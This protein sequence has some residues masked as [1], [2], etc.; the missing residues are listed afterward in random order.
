MLTKEELFSFFKI[1]SEKHED[2]KTKHRGNEVPEPVLEVEIRYKPFESNFSK[3]IFDLSLFFC[4]KLNLTF[5]Q[6]DDDVVIYSRQNLRKI[7]K[8]TPEG[9]IAQ[10]LVQ[11]KDCLYHVK[12]TFVGQHNL[13]CECKFT[14]SSEK[15]LSVG[16]S[17]L[18]CPISEQR[19]R[20]RRTILFAGFLQLCF[21]VINDTICEIEFEFLHTASIYKDE[22]IVGWL[23]KT[24]NGLCFVINLVQI[25]LS[26]IP[27][28]LIFR[29]GGVF[30][31][32]RTNKPLPLEIQ[33]LTTLVNPIEKSRFVFTLKYDGERALVVFPVVNFSYF[34][35]V[36]QAGHLTFLEATPAVRKLL[37]GSIF[38]CEHVG[39][40]FWI[41]DVLFIKEADVSAKDFIQRYGFIK[42][43]FL[44]NELKED[45]R[46]AVKRFSN[47]ATANLHK[48]FL[49]L[50]LLEKNLEKLQGVKCD[51]F[52]ATPISGDYYSTNYKIKPKELCT[53]DLYVDKSYNLYSS[54][55]VKFSSTILLSQNINLDIKDSVVEFR[56]EKC[57]LFEKELLPLKIRTDKSRPNNSKTVADQFYSM[58]NLVDSRTFLNIVKSHSCWTHFDLHN[59][60]KMKMISKYCVSEPNVFDLCCGFLS[61]MWKYHHAA[62]KNVHAFDV[63]SEKRPEVQ[64]RLDRLKCEHHTETAFHINIPFDILD[65][66]KLEMYLLDRKIDK[67]SC[68]TMFF[69]LSFFYQNET[70][71]KKL[72]LSIRSIVNATKTAS[73]RLLGITIDG[74]K[75]LALLRQGGGNGSD[76]N[77][78]LV[79]LHREQHLKI[80]CR[81]GL[82][83]E[84]ILE[85]PDDNVFGKKISISMPKSKTIKF[86]EEYLVFTDH[87]LAAIAE[88]VNCETLEDVIIDPLSTTS[89][90]TLYPEL[91]NITLLS[92]ADYVSTVLYRTFVLKLSPKK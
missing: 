64:R 10:E 49:E 21:S 53:V 90:L 22:E 78:V 23:A 80:S 86:Q 19:K 69:N 13:V 82:D 70:V 9:E 73:V 16:F 28:N 61:D 33:H 15:D 48:E 11:E 29:C 3:C 35:L 31:E 60:I 92:C 1:C 34:F 54:D 43:A 17:L 63:D 47:H 50:L 77:Y 44:A 71:F 18:N 81:K 41:F 51:G 87:F 91:E 40:T 5:T 45:S 89:F 75:T 65:F 79:D 59:Y 66:K 58:F 27:K 74:S 56:I 76:K 72:L 36:F 39:D 88:E 7:T 32:I 14:C 38:D 12:K 52:I 25:S 55:K 4:E 6:E 84:K 26:T 68:I 85:N 24:I 2:L 62:V 20:H 83:I 57:T 37:N 42:Q 8:T 67:I 30:S 46:F